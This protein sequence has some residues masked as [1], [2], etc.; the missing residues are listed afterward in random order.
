MVSSFTKTID[1]FIDKNLSPEARSRTF[2]KY[3]SGVKE[4]LI[5][6]NKQALGVRIEPKQ[7]VD[8]REEA[9]LESVKPGGVILFEFDLGAPIIQFSLD[10]LQKVS[11]FDPTPDGIHYVEH[12]QI[13]IDDVLYNGEQVDTF[14][15]LVIT[16]GLIYARKIEQK[17]AIYESILLPNL[18]R[19]FGSLYTF[20][21][22]YTD[23]YSDERAPAV[24]VWPR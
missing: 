17:F 11:P 18:K 14:D 7:T 8:G 19:Q 13:W 1:V 23:D 21:F 12:H 22:K 20:N 15:K 2:A 6:Q 5:D 9:P 3:A 24:F 4:E 10:L 16:N